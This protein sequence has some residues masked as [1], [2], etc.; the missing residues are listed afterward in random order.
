M[1]RELSGSVTMVK[2]SLLRQRHREYHIKL[3]AKNRF[4]K[5]AHQIKANFCR[6]GSSKD[7]LSE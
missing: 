1:A 3:M 2:G 4:K 7:Q 5:K 6:I